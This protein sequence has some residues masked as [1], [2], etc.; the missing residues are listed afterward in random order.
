MKIENCKQREIKCKIAVYNR[1]KILWVIEHICPIKFNVGK[2]DPRDVNPICA[3]LGWEPSVI[4]AIHVGTTMNHD[5]AYLQIDIPNGQRRFNYRAWPFVSSEP[6][7]VL[8][9][10]VGS[11]GPS[12][13][14]ILDFAEIDWDKV[15]THV[16]FG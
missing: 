14:E 13:M 15:E 4:S 11:S 8:E 5:S 1:M 12:E 7:V 16:W 10:I 2:I 3:K 6:E 9:Q